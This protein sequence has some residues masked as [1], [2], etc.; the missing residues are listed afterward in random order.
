[1]SQNAEEGRLN[2][3]K[4]IIERLDNFLGQV[5]NKGQFYLGMNTLMIG[6]VLA[7]MEKL[8]KMIGESYW[9]IFLLIFFTV[10]SFFTIGF[11]LFSISPFLQSGN[12]GQYK[13]MIFFGGIATMERE[14]FV[15]KFEGQ[16]DSEIQKDFSKQIHIISKSLTE[17]YRKLEIATYF[18]VT[19]SITI[20]FIIY[21]IINSHK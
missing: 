7:N 4:F 14:D 11:T 9:L 15:Q 12:S 8:S 20:I 21:Q 18:F 5:N 19:Q 2:H 6:L 16:T 13:T 10:V 17:K 3:S 1:M